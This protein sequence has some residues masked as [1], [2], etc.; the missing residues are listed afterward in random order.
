MRPNMRTS[1]ASALVSDVRPRRLSNRGRR[2]SLSPNVTDLH[3]SCGANVARS[4]LRRASDRLRPSSHRIGCSVTRARWPFRH[5]N[6]SR[7]GGKPNSSG[8]TPGAAVDGG[9]DRV[10]VASKSGSRVREKSNLIGQMQVS[11]SRGS[12]ANWNYSTQADSTF[13]VGVSVKRVATAVGEG[14][15]AIRLVNLHLGRRAGLVPQQ[16]TTAN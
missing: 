11:D 12:S 7:G 16:A 15:I 3:A 9:G 2:R 4:A 1:S 13:G 5:A 8:E 6:V 14:S 10:A